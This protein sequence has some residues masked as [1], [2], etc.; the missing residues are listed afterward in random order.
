MM[1][2]KWIALAG[3]A[4]AVALATAGTA[5]GASQHRGGGTY[6]VTPLVS[7]QPGVAPVTDPNLVN[8]WGVSEGPTTPWWVANNGTDTSTLYDAAGTPF[9]PP[10]ARAARR[11]GAGRPDRN[12]VLRRDAVPGLEWNG[13]GAGEV[14]LRH[15]GR[16]DRRLASGHD[17]HG[18]RL[19]RLQVGRRLQGPRDCRRLAVRD[20]LP[21]RP[22]GHHRRQLEAREDAGCVQ[23]SAAAEGLRA[24]R[25][26][27]P[28][29]VH[30]RHVREADEG[31]QR[32][33]A[34]QG[35]R[36]RRRVLDRR[37][38]PAPRRHD[39]AS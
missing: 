28:G 33:A 30:L 2:S 6:T 7:D 25:D 12:R 17:A 23:R 31:Q 15:R 37:R 9:P 13:D 18:D 4:L 26:P 22:S 19:R 24:V 39:A 16:H 1:R 36:D 21:Q 38:A 11:H 27:E 5:A 20:R 14:H 35:A 29:R 8:A 32:R 34:R 10:P 3:A